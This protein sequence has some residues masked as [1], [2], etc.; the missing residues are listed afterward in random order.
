MNERCLLC[1]REG[2]EARNC[3]LRK[4]LMTLW[5]PKEIPRYRD[6]PYQNVKWYEDPGQIE[7][8]DEEE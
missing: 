5:P 7:E 2:N 4:T 1:V 8:E 3:E 6:C